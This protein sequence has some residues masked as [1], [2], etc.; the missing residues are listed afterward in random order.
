MMG[1]ALMLFFVLLWHQFGTDLYPGRDRSRE[2]GFHRTV[3][4]WSR[5]TL[6]SFL[7]TRPFRPCETSLSRAAHSAARSRRHFTMLLEPES[8]FDSFEVR[9]GP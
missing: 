1:Q 7:G 2:G 5:S 4:R 9:A 8:G 3:R 6:S